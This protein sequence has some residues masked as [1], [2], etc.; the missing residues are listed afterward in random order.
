[1]VVENSVG[2]AVCAGGDRVKELGHFSID[3]NGRT[4]SP[5]SRVADAEMLLNKWKDEYESLYENDARSTAIFLIAAT[6]VVIAFVGTTIVACW[7]ATE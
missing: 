1:M 7:L 3:T 4:S 2:R 6:I 5:E